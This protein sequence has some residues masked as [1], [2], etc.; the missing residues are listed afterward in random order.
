MAEFYAFAKSL[1]VLWLLVLFLG[2]VVWTF[3]PSRRKQ[4]GEHA[5]IPL[6]DDAPAR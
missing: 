2:I 6:Q 1:W 4:H 3:R 5:R